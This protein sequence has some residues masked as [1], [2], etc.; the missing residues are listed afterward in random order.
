MKKI[1]HK[2]TDISLRKKVFGMKFCILILTAK[3]DEWYF[4]T[5]KETKSLNKISVI[6]K[7]AK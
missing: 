7:Q 6:Q 5:A 1:Y 4:L 3:N 2:I